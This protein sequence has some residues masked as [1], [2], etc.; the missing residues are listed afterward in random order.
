MVHVD[1]AVEAASEA[2]RLTKA[3]VLAAGADEFVPDQPLIGIARRSAVRSALGGRVLLLWRLA[4]EDPVGRLVE[5]ALVAVTIELSGAR[6]DVRHAGWS[7]ASLLALVHDRC[8]PWCASVQ[9][10]VYRFTATRLARERAIAAAR[11]ASANTFQ[12]GLFDRRAERAHLAHAKGAAEL[13]AQIAARMKAVVTAGAICL[14]APELLLV[15]IPR[16]AARM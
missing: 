3:R 15:L 9:D 7:D 16:D 14:R 8:G 5:S 1:L 13:G 10:A 2:E 4:Y 6:F 12:A 11:V